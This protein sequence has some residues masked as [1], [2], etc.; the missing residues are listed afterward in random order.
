MG[1]GGLSGESR[2][3]M[4]VLLALVGG[5]GRNLGKRFRVLGL[6]TLPLAVPVSFFV[7][8]VLFM[9]RAE[10]ARPSQAAAPGKGASV[11]SE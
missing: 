10:A 2:R 3:S 1:V 8:L 7:T 4:Y 11:R 6:V 9:R 5:G